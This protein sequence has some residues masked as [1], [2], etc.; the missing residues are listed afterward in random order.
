MLVD[1][2][3]VAG[4]FNHKYAAAVFNWD[5]VTPTAIRFYNVLAVGNLDANESGISSVIFSVIVEIAK[6]NASS[7]LLIGWGG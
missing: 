2:R 7:D 5:F 3:P 1:R 6:D 4:G